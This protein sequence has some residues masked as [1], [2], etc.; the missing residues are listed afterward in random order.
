MRRLALSPLR[1]MMAMKEMTT[2]SLEL[3][4]FMCFGIS[5]FLV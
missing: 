5:M 2:E 3:H 4:A 1:E